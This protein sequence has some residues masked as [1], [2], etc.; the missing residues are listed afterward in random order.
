SPVRVDLRPEFLQCTPK[1]YP[2][3]GAQQMCAS[4]RSGRKVHLPVGRP[5]SG[6]L[7]KFYLEI[8]PDRRII[9]SFLFL[10]ILLDG[11]AEAKIRAPGT[12]PPTGRWTSLPDRRGVTQLFK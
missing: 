11:L 1:P 4:L 2:Y 5:V 7:R 3:R 9:Q 10:Y 8:H 12:G 6:A